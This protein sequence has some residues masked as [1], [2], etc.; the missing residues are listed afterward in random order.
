MTRHRRS[1]NRV[2]RQLV[3]RRLVL[4]M[5]LAALAGVLLPGV[6][7][8]SAHAF[9]VSSNPADGQVLDKAPTE[10]RLRLSE[11]VLLGSTSVTVVGGSV[12]HELTDLRLI[13]AGAPG[14]TGPGAT[15]A[16][17]SG[18]VGDEA[19]VEL[20][21]SLPPLGRGSYRVSLETVSA[22]D[23]HRTA[24]VLVF[25]IRQQVSAAGRQ[26]ASPRLD[27]ALLR[28][29]VLAG[30]CLGLGAALVR[31]LAR[32]ARHPSIVSVTVSADQV[33]A[34]A[35]GLAALTGLALLAVQLSGEGAAGL[36]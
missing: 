6:G 30:L 23:L 7:P 33:A 3:F 31:R 1:R 5:I 25:G 13:R 16:T 10:L 22:D 18:A 21:A 4:P 27:E 26:E 19:P 17:S 14:D 12:R 15:E 8:A 9:L 11:S 32:P 35:C 28:W 29:V 36:E 20:V 24:A 34:A 2:T